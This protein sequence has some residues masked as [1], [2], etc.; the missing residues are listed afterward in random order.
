MAL[1]I[2]HFGINKVNDN[3]IQVRRVDI[4]MPFAV[5]LARVDGVQ[6][7]TKLLR[8]AMDDYKEG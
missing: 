4:N 2:E 6:T 8:F 5:V 1:R 7:Y 3:I